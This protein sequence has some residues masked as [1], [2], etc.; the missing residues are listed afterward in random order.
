M[1][2]SGNFINFRQLAEGNNLPFY[3]SGSFALLNEQ[4]YK[5]FNHLQIKYYYDLRSD[6]EV[7]HQAA[8]KFLDKLGIS[9][10]NIAIDQN[11]D[12][13]LQLIDT[14]AHDY[15]SFYL[16]MLPTAFERLH[17]MVEH[18]II[19]YA[20]DKNISVVFGCSLGKDRTGVISAL[21]LKIL[22]FSD[23]YILDDYLLSSKYI[24]HSIDYFI[25]HYKHPS[26]AKEDYISQ[27]EP[28]KEAINYVLDY[29]QQN[30]ELFAEYSNRPAF[31]ELRRLLRKQ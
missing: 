15:G 7:I 29:L 2:P 13:F 21:L 18:F 17:S 16:R 10:V 5:Y 27:M 19:D 20:N 23:Q 12:P 6:R 4:D 26:Q 14:T 1:Y 9:K 8:C 3:R 25:K 24:L 30:Q 11:T 22:G 31:T 28:Q